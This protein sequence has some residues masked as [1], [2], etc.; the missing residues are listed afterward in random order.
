MNDPNVILLSL[1]ADAAITRVSSSVEVST[2]FVLQQA[3]KF[4]R[5]TLGTEVGGLVFFVLNE[6]IEINEES[7]M[8]T[9][10]GHFSYKWIRWTKGTLQEVLKT[11]P[12]IELVQVVAIRAREFNELPPRE[13]LPEL[14][15]GRY[16]Q[17]RPPKAPSSGAEPKEF[18]QSQENEKT[19]IHIDRPRKPYHALV[20][21]AL[22]VPSFG[23]FQ[24]NVKNISPSDRAMLYA[25]KMRHELCDIFHDEIDRERK[26]CSILGEFLS[27]GIQNAVTGKLK[28]DGGFTYKY[29]TV[30]EDGAPRLFIR[31]KLEQTG[32]SDPC[33]Q[34]S[35]DYL[36]NTRLVRQNVVNR[37]EKA[38][39]WFRARLPLILITH[40]GPNIQILGGVMTD[41]PQIEVLTAS[42]PMYFH[43]SN[44]D[45]SLDLARTLTALNIIFADLGKLYD[46]PPPLNPL[47]PVQH[48]Y[49]YPRRF[50]CG[51]QVITFTYLKRIDPIRLVFE[52]ETEEKNI[53]Y[54]KY[55]QQYGAEA[56]TIVRC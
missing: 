13:F 20:P 16:F 26:F 29:T 24:T 5:A 23:N 28:T 55:T 49:P 19:R 10:L 1:D 41:R 14:P 37:N 4:V 36:E 34:V 27:E 44:K 50:K 15:G 38:A 52:V 47:L 8:A 12:N 22:L 53:L 39:A 32:T 11:H 31:V 25:T 42:V 7:I 35:L 17:G 45:L 6:P 30:D 46:N 56:C 9:K 48:E 51:N 2:D 21:I 43:V 40:A 18:A 33:F 54:I 3:Q